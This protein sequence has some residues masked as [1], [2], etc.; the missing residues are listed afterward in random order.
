MNINPMKLLQIKGAWEK[1]QQNHPKFLQ[2]LKAA[3]KN[4]LSEGSVV[5]ISVTTADGRKMNTNIKVTR[6]DMELFEQIQE[7]VTVST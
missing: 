5:E 7:L 3:G 4:A 1:F 2:F 6:Q